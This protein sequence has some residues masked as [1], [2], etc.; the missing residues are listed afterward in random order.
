MSRILIVDDYASGRQVL[1]ERL[2]ILGYT[3]Q[4]VEHG[5]EALE[6][7]QTSHFDLVIT[8]NEMP[9]MSGLQL[10]QRLAEEKEHQHPPVIFL[11]G[12]SSDE[13]HNAA[14][15]AGACLVMNKPYRGQELLFAVSRLLKLP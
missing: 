6:A 7:M 10:L 14:R 1:R 8:D 13:L 4:E 12:N 2:E 11:T 5:A 15:E 3:C 9:V